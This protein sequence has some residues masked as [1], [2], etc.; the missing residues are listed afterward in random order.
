MAIEV[1]FEVM[2]FVR[3]GCLAEDCRLVVLLERLLVVLGSL[4]KSKTNVSC[5]LGMAR[6]NRDSV[7]T[8]LIR[9]VPCRRT[10]CAIG[11]IEAR[12]ELFGDDQK[13]IWIFRRCRTTLA[14]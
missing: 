11:L 14:R 4:I 12:L 5:F 7:C 13:P 1:A 6:F 8:A 2:Q 9:K 10:S 3:I